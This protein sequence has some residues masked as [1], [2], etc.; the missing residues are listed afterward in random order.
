MHRLPLPAVLLFALA[1]S[2]ADTLPLN[3]RVNQFVVGRLG[4]RVGGGECAHLA[5]EALRGS[6]A[7]FIRPPD[8]PGAGDYVWGTLVGHVEAAAGRAVEKVE[9]Q[10]RPG[11]I[12]Q[13][14]GATFRTGSRYPQH[15]SVVAAVNGRG[16]PTAVHEQNIGLAGRTDRTVRRSPIDLTQLTAGWVRV[17]RPEPRPARKRGQW[18]FTVVNNTPNTREVG[19][20]AGPRRLFGLTLSAANTQSS[21]AHASAVV[22]GLP[23]PALVVGTARVPAVDGAC[24]E[25]LAKDGTVSIRRLP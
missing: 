21:Y 9:V 6:G 8:S 24:F 1:A 13:Y 16:M 20:F 2:A 17:Y 22:I 4:E 18:A 5:T 19:I 10:A 25:L 12:I 7:N 15:T 11:D 23:A 14:R 3:D